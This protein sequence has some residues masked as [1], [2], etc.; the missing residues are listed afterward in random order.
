MND[1]EAER[2][3]D[4]AL[5]ALVSGAVRAKARFVAVGMALAV[6]AFVYAAADSGVPFW[7]VA[8]IGVLGAVLIVFFVALVW[9]WLRFLSPSARR[10]T[11]DV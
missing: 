1:E 2:P 11:H 3:V 8:L 6:G 4:P 9:F 10:N 5:M 7:L